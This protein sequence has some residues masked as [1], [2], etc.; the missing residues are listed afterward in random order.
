MKSQF[1]LNRVGSCMCFVVA[2]AIALSF[3]GCS[4]TQ[5][6][7]VPITDDIIKEVQGVQNAAEEF[8]YY[9]SKT[10]TLEL[11]DPPPGSDIKDNKLNRPGASP[12]DTVIIAAF[13]PG[14]MRKPPTED[15]FTI[16]F[17][18]YQND[19]VI[20]FRSQDGGRY[21]IV[22]NSNKVIYYGGNNYS[23]AFHGA[24]EPPYLMIMMQERVDSKDTKRSV[25]GLLKQ[26]RS[27]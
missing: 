12:R 17:E 11:V 4:T 23:V 3:L 22:Y 15:T 16:A 25:K 21:E 1:K 26:R 24:N 27:S 10:I 20:Q 8:Q 13:T 9:I 18:N 14:I 5:S 19:P 6:V 7:M 2:I